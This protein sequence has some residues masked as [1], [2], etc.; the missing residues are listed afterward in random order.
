[1][2]IVFEVYVIVRYFTHFIGFIEVAFY[3]GVVFCFDYPLK[4]V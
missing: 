1:M 4:I 2:A 3:V